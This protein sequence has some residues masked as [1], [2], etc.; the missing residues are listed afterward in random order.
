MEKKNYKDITSV[1]FVYGGFFQGNSRVSVISSNIDDTA[2]WS[3]STPD[4][5][6]DSK[7]FGNLSEEKWNDFRRSLVERANV[8]SWRESYV[9]PH[10]LDG[11]QWSLE[12][13]FSDGTNLEIDGSNDYPREWSELNAIMA[14][15]TGLHEE[16]DTDD[17]DES[18]VFGEEDDD[19][20][21]IDLDELYDKED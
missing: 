11:F 2:T 17:E 16:F 12:V 18:E 15:L 6:D 9:E 21:G 20:D 5:F 3:M 8:L 4:D 14:E 10:I 7:T 1:E 19:L 13:N